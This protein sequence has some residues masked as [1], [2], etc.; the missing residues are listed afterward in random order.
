MADAGRAVFVTSGAAQRCS[1]YWGPY[2]TSK[3]ALDALVRTYAAEIA[4]TAVRANLFSPGP[5]R[6]RMRALAMP[7]EDPDYVARSRTGGGTSGRDVFS[8]FQRQWR[9]L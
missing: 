3:A 6:T 9:H 2:S 7:G 5:T 1:A 4:T 8:R